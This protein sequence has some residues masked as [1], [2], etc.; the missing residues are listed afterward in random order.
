MQ[1]AVQRR[2]ATKGWVTRAIKN[3]EKALK[4]RKDI[5]PG[6]AVDD[7]IF[8][9]G[10]SELDLRLA[11]F[12][13]AQ[14][15]VEAHCPNEEELLNCIDEAG[16]FL[17]RISV[18][19]IETLRV[20]KGVQTGSAVGAVSK[21][22]VEDNWDSRSHD[23]D[24]SY[25]AS[26]L[27]RLPK[28]ELPK[29]RGDV[30]QWQSFW[31][32]FNA[33]VD[34]TD[35]PVISKFTYLD[36]LLE[37]E[38]KAA[39]AGLS[40]T[41]S[42]YDDARQI[43]ED[44]YG[45]REKIAF[46]HIQGLL[47]MSTRPNAGT[48]CRAGQLS[49]L[50]DE[51]QAHVRSLEALD[52]TGE[53][54]GV[55][56]TPVVLSCL[57]S[58]VRLEWARDGEGHEDDLDF[59]L[60]F[61]K[62][63]I[64]RRDTADSF[65][66]IGKSNTEEKTFEAPVATI[67]ALQ[68][69]SKN[70]CGHCKKPSHP[71]HKCWEITRCGSVSERKEKVRNSKLCFKCLGSHFA[72]QCNEKCSKC[73]AGH[74]HLLCEKQ[75]SRNSTSRPRNAA[76][77]ERSSGAE[78][79]T[80]NVGNVSQSARADNVSGSFVS[81]SSANN[82]HGQ[83]VSNSSLSNSTG[84][85]R[86]ILP[87][88]TVR[89]RGS[90]GYTDA[91]LLFDS[92]SD[93]SYVS[94]SLVKRVKPEW[95]SSEPICFAAFGGGTSAK[96]QLHNVYNLELSNAAK[97]AVHVETINAVEVPL[98]CTPL[99][100]PQ[101]PQSVLNS[102][103]EGVEFHGVEAGQRS[104]DI[105]IGIDTYWDFM[106]PGLKRHPDG[107]VAQETIFGWVL[108]G[109][110]KNPKVPKSLTPNSRNLSHQLLCLD[111]HS[112]GV[113][114]QTVRSF[115]ELESIGIMKKETVP[116]DPV[117]V[118]FKESI[119]FVRG[120]YEVALPWRSDFRPGVLL[121][122]EMLA[123]KRLAYLSRRLDRDHNLQDQY[124]A[125]FHNY[126]NLGIIE[127]VKEEEGIGPVFYLP[128]RP[129]V[130]ET[131]LSS[132]VRPVF[133]ASATGYNQVS[134]ND[135]M[136]TGPSLMPSLIEILIRFRRWQVA[137]T[138]DVS[139]AFLQIGVREQ[140]Q[141]VHRFLWDCNG[142]VRTMKF[143]RVPF[144]NKS[145]PFLLNATIKHHLATY[146]LSLAREELEENLFVDDWL[147]GADTD[148]DSCDLFDNGSQIFDK[149]GMTL[150]K[151]HSN[152]RVLVGKFSQDLGSKHLQDDSVKVL[153]M[154]WFALEDCFSFDGV[155]TPSI[156]E[157]FCS[158]R[159]VLSFTSRLFDP[160]GFLSPFVMLAKI[161]FQ[162]V[163]T[164]GLGWDEALPDEMRDRF[165]SW[166][167]GIVT[168]QSWRIPRC[169]F[170]GTTWK[171]S[172]NKL[173]LHVFSDASM[174][175]YGANVYVRLP[176]G[177]GGYK[178]SL[179]TSK[180]K[181]SPL[182]RVTLPRLELLGALLAARLLNFVAKALKLDLQKTVYYC[183]SDS[184]IVLAWIRTNASKFKAFV[185]NRVSEIQELTDP[186]HWSHVESA[187]NPADLVSRGLLAKDLIT[188]KLW[189]EGPSWLS[190]D[191][192]LSDDK[193]KLPLEAGIP[194]EMVST[195]LVVGSS[196][197]DFAIPVERWSSFEKTLRITG[198]VLRF[199]ENLRLHKVG[200]SKEFQFPTRKL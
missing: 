48:K 99:Q 123:R 161:L 49:K 14:S 160:L 147:T 93:R 200:Q 135:C 125:V 191:L 169:F 185:G 52:I 144:G 90:Q 146:P 107:P 11:S 141:S 27:V 159:T 162:E 17:D 39:I 154:K 80:S 157:L 110:L 25:N 116:P 31:D 127:E 13:K 5:G 20:R 71:A 118:R 158:K 45:R 34:K 96:G 89:V 37:G 44:R 183:W 168:L 112:Q 8:E 175:A 7:A 139:K 26:K 53:Q 195:C 9:E 124:D 32:K 196:P 1:A 72:R 138:A 109:C 62:T 145:S 58:E 6:G 69:S 121:N 82:V 172:V 68:L 77:T 148:D 103:G 190:K 182:K 41:N 151:C 166:V 102:F 97:G 95:V 113:T 100:R 18:I 51:V 3:L 130:R 136:E 91:T 76:T 114:D 120:R 192:V 64:R 43:L 36:S 19:R 66:E 176:D 83:F 140:D 50:Y 59:L 105:L 35:I 181:V 193:V 171:E 155:E 177:H 129:V 180:G 111:S 84:D 10:L 33:L 119:R 63:D 199:I 142:T 149:A 30:T 194:E 65:K 21:T 12:R 117:H 74:H 133:D 29:F 22:D 2:S 153:G 86:T 42:H 73:G 178:V 60:D 78:N 164:L 79:G 137:L 150:A 188:S 167:S 179:V 55:F 184:T 57:P 189:L 67:A 126:E 106:K 47:R 40:I 143:L 131:S 85:L 197:P 61:L 87:L 70:G 98:I 115:W 101:V 23:S 170:P 108:S 128:H 94:S 174:K 122:N 187:D 56:L 28:I 4:E 81:N 163:W 24:N 165:V 88:A 134:L 186:S 16:T 46:A 156:S 15:D 75:G 198:Y 54:Y 132:K 104:I 92:G 38:A 152:S 173:E